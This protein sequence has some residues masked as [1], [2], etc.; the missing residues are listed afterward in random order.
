M[1]TLILVS[2][3]FALFLLANSAGKSYYSILGISKSADA[4]QIKKAYRKLAVKYHPD[5]NKGNPKAEKKFVDIAKAYEVLSDK[6]KRDIYDRFGEEG[7]KQHQQSGGQDAGNIFSSFFGGGGFQFNMGDD[8]YGGQQETEEDFKG[9]DIVIPIPVT[10]EDLFKGKS[11]SFKRYRTAHEDGAEPRD[12][13]CRQSNTIRMTIV[14]GVLQRQMDNNCAECQDRFKVIQ[15]E[16]AIVVDIEPGM[17]DGQKIVFYGE[18]DASAAKRAGDL[19]FAIHTAPH[20]TFE[21]LKNRVDLKTRMVLSLKESLVGFTR[22]ITHLDGRVISFTSEEVL[23]P[24]DV[25]M[26]SE[27]GMPHNENRDIRGDLYIEFAVQFPASLT[28]AQKDQLD[29]IL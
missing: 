8:M 23:K 20:G 18:G 6:K 26:I 16:S 24:G 17:K 7:L 29:K 25:R 10:L 4:G 22:S 1:K 28:S 19:I 5:R 3:L 15:K 9:E 11:I 13:K 2:I 12:C 21:R 27:E 14:N